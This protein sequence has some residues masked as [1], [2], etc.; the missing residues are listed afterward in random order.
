M[1][2]PSLIIVIVIGDI[3]KLAIEGIQFGFSIVLLK[4][5]SARDLGNASQS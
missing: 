4:F 3:A 5:V 2:S 1:R